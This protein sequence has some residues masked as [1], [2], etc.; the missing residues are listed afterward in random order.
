MKDKK[1]VWIYYEDLDNS[2]SDP[3]CCGGPSP[4]IVI[5]IYSSLQ[6]AIKAGREKNDLKEI[7]I[8]DGEGT[9]IFW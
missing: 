7:K 8:D 5:W 4:D 1:T 2:C 3:D 9:H 6:E